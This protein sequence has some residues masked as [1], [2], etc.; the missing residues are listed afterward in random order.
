MF[1]GVGLLLDTRCGK[2]G[3]RIELTPI[4]VWT[5]L[6]LGEPGTWGRPSSVLGGK[7]QGA[8]Q[9]LGGHGALVYGVVLELCVWGSCGWLIVA[10]LEPCVAGT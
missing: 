9:T 7:A 2:P 6:G 3:I 10:F 4:A 8:G 1:T 5:D